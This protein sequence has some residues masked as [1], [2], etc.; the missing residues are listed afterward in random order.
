MQE[1]NK[2]LF[3]L[4]KGA[5][6]DGDTD[7]KEIVE[8]HFKDRPFEI[9]FFELTDKPSSEEIKKVIENFDPM[10]VVA[11]GGDGTVTLLAGIIGNSA[12]QLGILPA[13]SANGMAKELK[14]PEVPEEACSVLENGTIKCCDAILIDDKNICI[15]ISDLGLNAQ[16]IKYFD[17]GKLRGKLGYMKV[18]L[19]TLWHRSKMK[20]IIQS[21]NV[22]I[23]RQAF[24]VLLAN[25]S[26]YGFGTVVNPNSQLDDGTF[27]V[28]VVRRLSLQ[29]LLK[30]LIKPGP[31]NPKH[32]EIFPSTAVSMQTMRPVHFQVDGE[33]KGKI[34]SLKASVLRHYINMILPRP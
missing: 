7:W 18:I 3:V 27:E 4:N 28:V 14:I 21:K 13:G 12:R 2:M 10:K 24:M 15:H 23:R 5:G 29:A 16:L 20:V 6:K 17:E 11:V 33:Y 32:I 1:N 25:A 34:S 19:R 8:T 9:R 31:F 22:E 30:M 26:M